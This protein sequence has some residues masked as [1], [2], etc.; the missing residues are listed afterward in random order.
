MNP[1]NVTEIRIEALTTLLHSQFNDIISSPAWQNIKE[2]LRSG[3]LDSNPN[4][5]SLSLKI[6]LKL[7]SNDGGDY[8][9]VKEAYL[10][11]INT[12]SNL[13]KDKT[14]IHSLPNHTTGLKKKIHHIMIQIFK[15]MTEFN[16]DLTKYW[17]RYPEKYVDEIIT[18]TVNLLSFLNSAHSQKTLFP[19]HLISIADP[20]CQWLKYWCHSHFGRSRFILSLG[21]NNLLLKFFAEKLLNFL[22][23]TSVQDWLTINS[24]LKM[25]M[26][27]GA[28]QEPLISYALF[29]SSLH[30]IS[31]II[32]VR[33]IPYYQNFRSDKVKESLF[34]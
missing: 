34:L 3:L 30:F 11:M 18:S 22:E 9:T 16:K 5:S 17:I 13:Y 19:V 32:Q 20:T 10:N 12:I 24:C 26:R 23:N 6:H 1:Y 27:R 14:R 25:G 7:L 31:I 33:T 15:V 29:Q 4:I 8:Y 21:R 2:G 28:F